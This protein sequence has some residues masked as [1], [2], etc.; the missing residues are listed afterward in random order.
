MSEL[1]EPL[2]L[3]LE[4]KYA[5]C[6][7]EAL[8]PEW[9]EDGCGFS[10]DCPECQN[11]DHEHRPAFRYVPLPMPAELLGLAASGWCDNATGPA[12]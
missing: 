11:T 6:E 12:A 4:S 5:H 10:F 2:R 3:D 8:N 9:H 1:P 7:E